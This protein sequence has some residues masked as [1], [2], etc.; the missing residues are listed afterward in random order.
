[1]REQIRDAPLQLLD[2]GGNAHRRRLASLQNP[3]AGGGLQRCGGSPV[4][5][6]RIGAKAV[7][8]AFGRRAPLE[9][10]HEHGG[11]AR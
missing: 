1:M 3:R 10:R 2:A 6:G 11:S 8:P 4:G 5:P 9:P 7:S